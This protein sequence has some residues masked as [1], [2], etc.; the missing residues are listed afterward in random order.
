MQSKLTS[1]AIILLL[2][3]KWVFIIIFKIDDRLGCVLSVCK[4]DE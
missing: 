1:K 3:S 4:T 2:V